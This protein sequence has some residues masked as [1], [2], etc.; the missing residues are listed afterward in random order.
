M[1]KIILSQFRKFFENIN[2]FIFKNK[3]K[4]I[5]FSCLV[6]VGIFFV[7]YFAHAIDSTEVMDGMI[8]LLANLLKDLTGFVINLILFL[9]HFFLKLAQY[10]DYTD[11]SIVNVGWILVRDVANMFFV[12][13]LLVIA[14]EWFKTFSKNF[15]GIDYCNECFWID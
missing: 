15:I 9:F 2:Q 7:V 1:K 14:F 4:I 3:K 8:M 5:L 12:V 13:I 10:N 6:F 11:T